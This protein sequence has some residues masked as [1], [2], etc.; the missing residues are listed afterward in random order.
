MKII[1]LSLPTCVI[2]WLEYLFEIDMVYFYPNYK[3]KGKNNH[4]NNL[5]NYLRDFVV[6]HQSSC[7]DC[8][9]KSTCC[10]DNSNKRNCLKRKNINNQFNQFV[11]SLTSRGKTLEILANDIVVIVDCLMC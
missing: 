5:S 7:S 3:I 9:A 2:N 8:D 11:K 10:T 1:R 6:I 4:T